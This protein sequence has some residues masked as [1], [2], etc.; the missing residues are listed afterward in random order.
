M[1]IEADFQTSFQAFNSR[2]TTAG[3]SKGPQDLLSKF[4]LSLGLKKENSSS[5]LNV[6]DEQNTRYKDGCE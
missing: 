6:E 5:T 3:A 2:T 1:S 4:G